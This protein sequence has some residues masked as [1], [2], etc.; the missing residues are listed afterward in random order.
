M[1]SKWLLCRLGTSQVS[2]DY[3]TNDFEYDGPDGNGVPLRY[4][5]SDQSTPRYRFVSAADST[6]ALTPFFR[7]RAP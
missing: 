5:G 2:K 4:D 6:A 7:T 3:R 1:F